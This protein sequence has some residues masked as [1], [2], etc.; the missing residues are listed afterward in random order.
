V[1]F[2]HNRFA[3]LG[4][5]HIDPKKVAAMDC[6]DEIPALLEIVTTIAQ[7]QVRAEDFDKFLHADH[8]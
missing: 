3:E 5:S 8:E 4:L 1:V 6:V 2:S 7:E